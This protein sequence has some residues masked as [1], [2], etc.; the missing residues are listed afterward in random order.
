MMNA[1][2]SPHSLVLGKTILT[3]LFLVL[4][5]TSV[6]WQ[7]RDFEFIYYDD[8]NYIFE[9]PHIENGLT[10]TE[11]VW[12]FS[13]GYLN[14]WH[15][16]TW[17]SHMIDI[18]LF[19][20]W[21]G[22]H[23]L[24]NLFLHVL[25]TVLLFLIFYNMTDSLWRS[26][27]V[28]VFFAIHPLHVQSVAW[29]SERKD[30]LSGFFWMLTLLAYF[31]YVRGP[32]W[33][34]YLWVLLFFIGGLLS[35]PMAVTLP[36]VLLLLDF[37]PLNRVHAD[38]ADRLSLSTIRPLLLEKIP[39]FI[40]SALSS[41]ITFLVQQQ[42]GAVQ[43]LETVP[44]AQRLA[45]AVISYGDYI[46]KTLYPE[47]LALFYPYPRTFPLWRIGAAILILTLISALSIR[48]IREKP[49]LM[50]GWLWFLGTLVPVIGLVQVG[51]QSMAD[52]YTYIPLIG[53][54]IMIAWSIPA[55]AAEKKGFRAGIGAVGMVIVMALWT[56]ARIQTRYW[57]DSRTLF[58]RALQVTSNNAIMHNSL[59]TALLN[60]NK[61]NEALY[62][63][64][65]ALEIWPEF[66]DALYNLGVALAKNGNG[67]EAIRAFIK[68]L[69]LDPEYIPAHNNLADALMQKGDL[70]GAVRHL[71]FVLERRPNHVE[72]NINMGVALTRLGQVEAAISHY[73]RA[74]DND[75]SNPEAYNNMG[76]L[77][78]QKKMPA[79]ARRCFRKA[80]DLRPGYES[81]INNLRLLEGSKH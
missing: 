72:A 24:T 60:D 61:I 71:Q 67:D 68:T 69:T 74:I 5:T 10:W 29:V 50:V 43:S 41:V 62:H 28:A 56:S 76:V 20:L 73:Q 9:N 15:P 40:L 18:E 46:L 7:V 8:Q 25:S 66:I 59:G 55:P 3:C 45:N 79:E 33:L 37:W 78:V 30:V 26:A 52:R 58:E 36:F 70:K 80:L 17:L 27:L 57:K 38:K 1:Q 81:A 51:G 47:K 44:F 42:S 32:G 21:P 22:G 39:L 23:H 75:P 48:F 6:F 54:F 35:K 4:V 19:D 2:Q 65:E 12:A 53:L 11:V 63:Y 14:N 49:F 31:R 77:F 13:E 64:R 34:R 16:L